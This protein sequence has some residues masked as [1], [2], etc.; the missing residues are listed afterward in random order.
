MPLI[1]PGLTFRVETKV[2]ELQP[3]MDANDNTNVQLEKDGQSLQ[4]VKVFCV[5]KDQIAPIIAA[6]IN[7]PPTDITI[8]VL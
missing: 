6:T 1:P 2:E 3:E 8:P 4:H 5:R 7:M